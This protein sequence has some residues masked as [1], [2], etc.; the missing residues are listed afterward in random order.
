MDATIGQNL[1]IVSK[2]LCILGRPYA[3]AGFEPPVYTSYSL[4]VKKPFSDIYFL[5]DLFQMVST[6]VCNFY[7]KLV[8]ILDT[9][10]LY[11]W[12]G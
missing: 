2:D 7:G 12:L 3:C 5:G 10:G 4:S 9:V 8:T 11:E 1:G 6:N